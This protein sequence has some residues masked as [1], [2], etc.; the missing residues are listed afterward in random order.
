MWPW[1]AQNLA[2]RPGCMLAPQQGLAWVYWYTPVIPAFGRKRQE[3]QKFQVSLSYIVSLRPACAT[4]ETSSKERKGEE[5]EREETTDLEGGRFRVWWIILNLD[6]SLA[7]EPCW[8]PVCGRA[9][10]HR[11]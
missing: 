7:A 4:E 8:K 9:I 5:E 11:D 3:D 6:F 10:G 2:C 1:L